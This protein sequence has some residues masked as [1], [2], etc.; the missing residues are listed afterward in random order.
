VSFDSE[1]RWSGKLGRISESGRWLPSRFS[2]KIMLYK[3]I[4]GRRGD[5][6]IMPN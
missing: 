3:N 6:E 1:V 5:A 2:R 4:V